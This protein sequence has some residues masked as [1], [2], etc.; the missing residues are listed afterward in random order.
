MDRDE[1][2][3][4]ILISIVRENG[5]ASFSEFS[6]RLMGQI[7]K[8]LAPYTREKNL[9]V[10]CLEVGIPHQLINNYMNNEA[11]I[12]ELA[13]HLYEEH[14]IA[15]DLA[16][17][18]I[19]VWAN[20]IGNMVESLSN[21][22]SRFL[23]DPSID[24]RIVVHSDSFSSDLKRQEHS[25]YFV[26]LQNR[27]YDRAV[28]KCIKNLSEDMPSTVWYKQEAEKLVRSITATKT[29]PVILTGYER[30]GGTFLTNLAIKMSGEALKGKSLLSNQQIESLHIM[31]DDK[32]FI[33]NLSSQIDQFLTELMVSSKY[34]GLK[35]KLRST[36]PES[37]S[38]YFTS[39]EITEKESRKGGAYKVPRIKA[40]IPFGEIDSGEG[41]SGEVK[42]DIERKLRLADPLKKSLGVLQII[43]FASPAQGF[44]KLFASLKIGDLPQRF[45]LIFDKTKTVEQIKE[46]R[47]IINLKGM[48]R[49]IFIVDK[50]YFDKWG[51]SPDDKRWIEDNFEIVR[52]MPVL[53]ENLAK[54]L[55][56]Q[57][58]AYDLND[59]ENQIIEDFMIGLNYSSYGSPGEVMHSLR[60]YWSNLIVTDSE[61]GEFT[62]RLIISDT[63]EVMMQY[64]VWAKIAKLIEDKWDSIIGNIALPTNYQA[65]GENKIRGRI[66]IKKCLNYVIQMG[67]EGF[68]EMDLLEYGK[69]LGRVLFA[70]ISDLYIVNICKRLI[71]VLKDAQVISA[72]N[73]LDDNSRLSNPI[74]TEDVW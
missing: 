11:I 23:T 72:A 41:R 6:E 65:L 35:R 31:P 9:I 7:T 21:H 22:G 52:C 59:L 48:L 66:F 58:F 25:L 46:L 33:S 2:I 43:A 50:F 38:P 51:Q 40:K 47:P 64:R 19:L 13:H 26:G 73:H 10:L 62:Q 34:R 56:N 74:G 3:R 36:F 4:E 5:L 45:L 39:D 57:Y 37:S 24:S 17:W 16:H 71:S 67:Y 28:L 20:A 55:C 44:G 30:F 69:E 18:A 53:S 15:Q 42:K 49:F 8:A 61:D 54:G 70:D 32:G 68:S 1:K 29:K 12:L 60:S 63:D 14:G 27:Y